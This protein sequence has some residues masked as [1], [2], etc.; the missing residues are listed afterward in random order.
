MSRIFT[1]FTVLVLH[2]PV[3]F[4]QQANKA[5]PCTAAQQKQLD[6]WIGEWDL[7]W[8]GDKPGE[9]MHGTNSIKRIMDG[10]V[11]QE[12]F[13]AGESGHL[14][15]TSV[16][17]FDLRSGMWK[18]TWVDNEGG[19]L[20]F[21]GEFKD[22]NMIL[23]RETVRDG[24]KIKQRMVFKNISADEMDWNWEASQDGGKTWKVNWPIHYKRRT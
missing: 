18:Q 17:T 7:T 20:D 3:M 23:R 4:P 15:G 22:G 12:N 8:P 2:V 14:R 13:S 11:V 10:C 16:S 5:N 19:Y 9:V 1:L 24:T 21:V 6:F